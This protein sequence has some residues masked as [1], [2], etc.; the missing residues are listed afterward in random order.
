MQ[1]G[2]EEND[3]EFHGS[4]RNDVDSSLTRP[5]IERRWGA[6]LPRLKA[7]KLELGGEKP[8]EE[9]E[10][11]VDGTDT[12]SRRHET[13]GKKGKCRVTYQEWY[14]SEC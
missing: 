14:L 7:L 8:C 5:I 12:W 4:E 6:V 10:G 2:K 9:M 3:E 11:K 13:Y 1:G